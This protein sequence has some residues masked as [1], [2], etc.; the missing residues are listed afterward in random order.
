MRL[1]IC[2]ALAIALLLPLLV[3]A[4]DGLSDAVRDLLQQARSGDASA[5]FA[6]ANAYDGGRGAPRNGEEAMRWYQAAAEQ[7]HAE[8]Q[9]SVG[10][11]LQAAKKY[12]EARSWYEKAAAQNHALATNNLAYLYDLGLG[13]GQDRQQALAFYTK[14]ADLGWAESMWNIANM[15]GAGQLGHPPN[16]VLACIW[17]VRAARYASPQERQLLAHVDRAKPNFERRLSSE[18]MSDCRVQAQSWSP[19]LAATRTDLPRSA[20]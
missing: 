2:R 3:F 20:P 1:H 18:Q 10:S 15:Y 12:A 8:A 17:T 4:Q 13:I 6:V 16:L 14:A 5:Q 9:N 11:G 19:A 7:G